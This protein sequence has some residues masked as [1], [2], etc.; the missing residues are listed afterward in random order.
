MEAVKEEKKCDIDV[1]LFSLCSASRIFFTGC[2]VLRVVVNIFSFFSHIII[3]EWA[4]A[5]MT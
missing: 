1:Y 3:F 5:I 2:N 4:L